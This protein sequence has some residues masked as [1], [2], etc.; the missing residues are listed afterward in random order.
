MVSWHSSTLTAG[1]GLSCWQTGFSDSAVW[2]WESCNQAQVG[3]PE[4]QRGCSNLEPP[5]QSW[6]EGAMVW[7]PSLCPIPGPLCRGPSSEHSRQHHAVTLWHGEYTLENTQGWG[8]SPDAGISTVNGKV[9]GKR[10]QTDFF[11]LGS[12]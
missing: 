9:L 5:R 1:Y 11:S 4:L 3:S 8:L 12:L 10:G 7:L 6:E 2:P